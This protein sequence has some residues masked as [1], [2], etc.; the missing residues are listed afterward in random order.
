M[1][2]TCAFPVTENNILST[3]PF[4]PKDWQQIRN[5]SLAT[6]RFVFDLISKEKKYVVDVSRLVLDTSK[7]IVYERSFSLRIE[8]TEDFCYFYHPKFSRSNYISDSEVFWPLACLLMVV[9]GKC[10]N[11][12]LLRVYEKYYR[13][14]TYIDFRNNRDYSSSL[15]R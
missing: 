10:S 1:G 13:T 15:K 4:N 6:L 2:S 8:N 5:S 14:P 3:I 11:L 7:H 9:V 12:A